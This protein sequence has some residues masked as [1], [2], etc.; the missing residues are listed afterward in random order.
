MKRFPTPLPWS[1]LTKE[2][3]ALIPRHSIS[4]WK[5]PDMWLEP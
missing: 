3:E 2:R 4:A 1:F 5:S